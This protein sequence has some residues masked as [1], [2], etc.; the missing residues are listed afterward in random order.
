MVD[1]W[2]TVSGIN[3]EN[4]DSLPTSEAR[5]ETDRNLADSFT[6][7][8]NPVHHLR[9]PQMAPSPQSALDYHCSA[10]LPTWMRFIIS[11][12]LAHATLTSTHATALCLPVTTCVQVSSVSDSE[13]KRTRGGGRGESFSPGSEL[14]KAQSTE[15]GEE[16]LTL[17]ISHMTSKKKHFKWH[18]S[19]KYV[20]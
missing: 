16:I 11:H 6:V 8:Q 12:T 3:T 18:I 2:I 13:G 1:G 20:S 5:V 9:W 10:S 14:K 4:Q 17:I 7:F 15:G 19:S